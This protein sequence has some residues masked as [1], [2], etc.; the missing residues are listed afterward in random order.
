MPETNNSSPPGPIKLSSQ[1]TTDVRFL[2]AFYQLQHPVQ[3]L[4]DK[5][6]L[7]SQTGMF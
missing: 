3:K 6:V 7:Q 2:R 5:T 1:S 4:Q